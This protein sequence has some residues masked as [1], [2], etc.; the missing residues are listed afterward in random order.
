MNPPKVI[1]FREATRGAFALQVAGH[2]T[3]RRILHP[4]LAVAMDFVADGGC[5][6]Q[7]SSTPEVENRAR[8]WRSDRV[9]PLDPWLNEFIQQ[10]LCK[11]EGAVPCEP[12][13]GRTLIVDLVDKHP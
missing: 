11:V 9:P 13:L 7:K 5:E 4:Y 8:C 3:N 2:G 10:I 12:I 1:G 6:V